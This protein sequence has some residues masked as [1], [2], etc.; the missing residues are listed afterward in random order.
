MVHAKCTQSPAK[1]RRFPG[2]TLLE[3]AVTLGLAGVL[4]T[5]MIPNFFSYRAQN[6]L[7]MAVSQVVQ[8]LGS[9]RVFSQSNKYDSLWGFRVAEGVLFQGSSYASRNTSADITFPMPD[10]IVSSGLQEAVFTQVTGRVV[11]GGVILLTAKNGDQV[12]IVVNGDGIEVM[13]A[14][15]EII[16]VAHSIDSLPPPVSSTSSDGENSSGST[17]SE[18]GDAESESAESSAPTSAA[19]SIIITSV[20]S[21]GTESAASVP[22]ASADSSGGDTASIPQDS[23][24][25]SSGAAGSDASEPTASA[26][27]VPPASEESSSSPSSLPMTP[28]DWQN[29]SVGILL[30]D[31]ESLG[32]LTLSGNGN[33]RITNPNA[34]VVVNSN[35]IAAVKMSG[36]AKITA[37]VFDIT[38]DPGIQK[39]GNAKIIGTVR[40]N[41]SPTPDPLIDVPALVPPTQ[42]FSKAKVSGNTSATLSPGTYV[43]GISVSANARVALSPG[44]YYLQ[45]GGLSISGN[46]TVTGMGVMIYNAPAQST[47][48]ISISGN[49]NLTLSPITSGTFAG[50]SIYQSRGSAVDMR[51]SGNGTL[52][53]DGVL[54]MP[55]ALLDIPGNGNVNLQCLASS[56]FIVNRLNFSGNGTFN[57]Q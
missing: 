3:V 30:L 57:V 7:S 46:A 55:G 53:M 10:T 49:A 54:Y 35:N 12:A 26:P 50:I 45:G 13:T 32:A 18:S 4:G 6:D 29:Q 17:E 20:S 37:T 25:A 43:G 5:V 36:N 21:A 33:M 2:F 38:G 1:R 23:G 44:I 40:T 41:V 34:T 22:A 16:D 31:Q 14:T 28:L 19:H 24:D 52:N 8:A 48:K 27:V 11:Q 51:I 42:T 56:R 15:Q 9:A 39:S 47:D